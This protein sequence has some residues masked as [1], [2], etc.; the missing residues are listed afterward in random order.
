MAKSSEECPTA[1][2]G[3]RGVGATLPRPS[4]GATFA[5]ST[6]ASFPR[7]APVPETTGL[8]L[9]ALALLM[10]GVGLLT[11][12]V[13]HLLL[14]RSFRGRVMRRW[15]WALLAIAATDMVQVTLSLGLSTSVGRAVGIA[16]LVCAFAFVL[17]T[18]GLLE[19]A[20]GVARER[21]ERQGL[22]V[23]AIGAVALVASLLT[24]PS[25]GLR[26]GEWYRSVGNPGLRVVFAALVAALAVSAW[27]AALVRKGE[28]GIR[29]V[30]LG[31]TG[32]VT[33]PFFI[34]VLAQ[35]STGGGIARSV[36]LLLFTLVVDALLVGVGSV[37]M[38]L[39]EERA[40]AVARTS[41]VERAER[42]ERLGM[43]AGSVAHDFNNVLAAVMAGVE[44]ARDPAASPAEVREELTAL[45]GAV[46]HGRAMAQGLLSFAKGEGTG[47]TLVPLGPWLV[48]Q[49]DRFRFALGAPHTVDIRTEAGADG[50]IRVDAT[51]LNQLVMNTI[52][53]SRDASPPGTAC[54]VEIAARAVELTH[55]RPHGVFL[56]RAGR[57]MVLT[58]SDAGPGF[59]PDALDKVFEPFFSTKG[60]LGTGLGLATVFAVARDA[61]GAVHAFN[62]K[63]GGAVIECWFPLVAS[64]AAQGRGETTSGE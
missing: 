3:R 27:R 50:R 51:R 17:L 60:A 58:V 56:L 61:G 24:E 53:N 19:H 23:I 33:R 36:V 38:A 52:L 22:A 11:I 29:L 31:L 48:D 12:V 2:S 40:R 9:D 26:P 44:L 64:D 45:Q 37:L 7:T 28:T 47:A 54:R 30:A 5:P 8:S 49:R 59:P 35:G 57:W 20:R 18:L 42:M 62:A 16:G 41:R 10:T 55:E 46:D 39:E 43:M 63:G 34:G 21:I 6:Q 4:G 13:V 14:W 1:V 25:G 15:A 32:A